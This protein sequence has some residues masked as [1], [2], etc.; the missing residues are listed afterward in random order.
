MTGESSE[1]QE[2]RTRQTLE[3]NLELTPRLGRIRPAHSEH[4]TQRGQGRADEPRS[5]DL[6]PPMEGRIGDDLVPRAGVERPLA[7]GL[8]AV[9]MHAD[10]GLD[11]GPDGETPAPELAGNER[12]RLPAAE[13]DPDNGQ[14]LEH[15]TG[16]Q[17]GDAF[18]RA[19]GMTTSA[20]AIA[21][22]LT[23][24]TRSL[25]RGRQVKA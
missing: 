24:Q 19:D 5:N 7:R 6:P 1:R 25:D 18:A 17:V 14:V 13:N 8:H 3:E 16:R 21:A 2:D 22:P 9:A 10:N 4:R 23:P 12:G 15:L 20:P 11:D